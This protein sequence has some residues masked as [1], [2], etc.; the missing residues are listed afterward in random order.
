MIVTSSSNDFYRLQNVPSSAA[1]WL[2]YEVPSL[3]RFHQK[4]ED[5][6]YWY[7]HK[8][9]LL[10]IIQL[11]YK[12]TGYVDYSALPEALQMQIAQEKVSW[13]QSTKEFHIT[14]KVDSISE[15][16]A[17]LHLLPS[18]PAAIVKGVWRLLAQQHH[19]DK[20]GDSEEFKRYSAAYQRIKDS[21]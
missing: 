17:V 20:G 21:L 16:Y 8:D 15:S 2:R 9:H 4:E 6:G 5:T 3:Y 11:V 10:D 12:E 19:P 18:A 13:K 1:Q 7:V 14:K